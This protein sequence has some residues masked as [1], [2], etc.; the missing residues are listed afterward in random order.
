MLARK[1]DYEGA[2]G[3]F[4]KAFKLDTNYVA[5]QFNLA[6]TLLVTGHTNEA[7][8]SIREILKQHPDYWPARE[9]MSRLTSA[10]S[11]GTN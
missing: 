10:G 5:A 3:W 11:G 1:H 7:V 2:R 6:N 9:L 4:E 8:G